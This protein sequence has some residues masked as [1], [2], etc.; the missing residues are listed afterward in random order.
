MLWLE[1]LFNGMIIPIVYENQQYFRPS[2]RLLQRA[3]CQT[4]WHREEVSYPRSNFKAVYSTYYMLDTAL[5]GS[6]VPMEP[7]VLCHWLDSIKCTLKFAARH[8]KVINKSCSSKMQN[9][10][11]KVWR[12]IIF[13]QCKYDVCCNNVC[14]VSQKRH[15]LFIKAS[16]Y[17]NKT[18]YVCHAT[19]C[20]DFTKER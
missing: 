19:V 3:C 8:L 4:Q 5:L 9:K 1:F 7:Y 10:T 14:T 17:L 6:A 18:F 15:I 11:E 16:I 20:Y 12:C 2:I 13:R